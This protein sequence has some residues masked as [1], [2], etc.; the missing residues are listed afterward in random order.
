MRVSWRLIALVLLISI[1]LLSIIASSDTTVSGAL[2]TR[3]LLLVKDQNEH[4]IG[5]VPSFSFLF[6]TL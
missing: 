3:E 5:D 1:H 2:S 4:V 6:F